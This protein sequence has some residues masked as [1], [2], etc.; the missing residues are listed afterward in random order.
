MRDLNIRSHPELIAPD[1]WVAP[2][3]TLVGRVRLGAQASVWFGA[4]LR[5]DVEPITIG[6]GTNIQ[7]LCCLHSDPGYPCTLGERVTVGHGAIVH[8]AV[9]EDEVLIGM[10]AILL[11]GAHI[12]QH[13]IIGAGAL[14]AEGKVIPPR[15]LV[16]GT[17]GRIIRDLTDEEV[18]RICRGAQH[19]IDAAIQY[20]TQP[21][22]ADR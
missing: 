11:N 16:V 22:P 15:S 6:A 18:E 9:I 20:R 12:G 5:G 10:G 8:G 13:A 4:V 1:A 14:I 21:A 2:N 17:P 3:A 19:Y 7:D